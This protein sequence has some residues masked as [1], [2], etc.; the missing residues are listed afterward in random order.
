MNEKFLKEIKLVRV[1][2]GMKRSRM[3]HLLCFRCLGEEK[4]GLG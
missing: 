2:C 4:H 1:M 3:G